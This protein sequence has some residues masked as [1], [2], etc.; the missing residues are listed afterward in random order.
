MGLF[1]ISAIQIIIYRL[2]PGP[3]AIFAENS[4][5]TQNLI[6][7]ISR[8]ISKKI[9][10][11]AVISIYRCVICEVLGMVGLRPR[12]FQFLAGY[13]SYFSYLRHTHQNYMLVP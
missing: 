1:P 2:V 11:Y 7:F 12:F 6:I 3:R 5:N 10:A 13:L 4:Q 8:Q 9:G